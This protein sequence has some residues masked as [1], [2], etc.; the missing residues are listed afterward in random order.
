MA[1]KQWENE[2]KKHENFASS[3]CLPFFAIEKKFKF[4]KWKNMKCFKID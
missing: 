3:N 4:T 1:K 2:K